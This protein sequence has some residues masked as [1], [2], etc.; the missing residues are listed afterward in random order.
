MSGPGPEQ[1][2]GQAGRSFQGNSNPTSRQFTRALEDG[3]H[4]GRLAS[5]PPNLDSNYQLK[6]GRV[7]RPRL[8]AQSPPEKRG[9]PG[10]LTID[11]QNGGWRRN[12][13]TPG[14]GECRPQARWR[15]PLPRPVVE[16][17]APPR[18]LKERKTVGIEKNGLACRAAVRARR[19]RGV[20]VADRPR[21]Q[22]PS[23]RYF[24]R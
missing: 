24:R 6:H 15:G 10:H 19:K 8:A 1:R 12:R 21:A 20:S 9:V 4:A 11:E 3:G 17:K 2:R 23:A 18:R 13:G 7:R 14:P 5:F 22:G 16:G